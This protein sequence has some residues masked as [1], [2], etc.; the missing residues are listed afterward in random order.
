MKRF[1]LIEDHTLFRESLA[2]LLEWRMQVESVQA[3]SL[4]EGRRALSA[5]KGTADFAIIDLDLPDGDGCELIEQLHETRPDL[6]ILAFTADQSVAKR[7]RALGAGADEVLPKK[8][9]VEQILGAT[10]RLVGG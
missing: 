9:P 6:P 3:G 7:V 5:V 10:Q 4:A 1:L 2:L 8:T